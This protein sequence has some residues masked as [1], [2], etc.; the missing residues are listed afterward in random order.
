MIDLDFLPDWYRLHQRR[1]KH[2]QRQWVALGLVFI[3]M[4]VWNS[5]ASRSISIASAELSLGETHRIRAEHIFENNQRLRM[6]L[7][8]LQK[9][10]NV[11]PLLDVRLDIAETITQLG[12]TIPE[13]AVLQRLQFKA[14]KF[15]DGGKGDGRSAASSP[16]NESDR[17]PLVL[18]PGDIWF[19][20]ILRA[21]V[22]DT[23][24]IAGLLYD[25]EHSPYFHRV[26]LRYLRSKS[27][28][29]EAAKGESD[30]D[31]STLSRG[32]R[33]GPGTNEFEIECYLKKHDRKESQRVAG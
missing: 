8:H 28:S 27:S 6:R 4:I 31:D 20:V 2:L 9:K 18:E 26:H 14:E 16:G 7:G 24:T 13:G 33:A 5:L 17:I 21:D 10:L 25:L 19:R 22:A 3:L 15:S 23:E 32:Q 11:T 12:D 30:A 1:Q 29:A